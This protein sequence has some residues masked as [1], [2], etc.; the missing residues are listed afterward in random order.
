MNN[1][2][3]NVQIDSPIVGTCHPRGLLTLRVAADVQKNYVGEEERRCDGV[4]Q[5]SNECIHACDKYEGSWMGTVLEKETH[6]SL[7]F[8]LTHVMKPVE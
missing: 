6:S 1:V 8:R 2:A 5:T 3:T 4:L 7:T